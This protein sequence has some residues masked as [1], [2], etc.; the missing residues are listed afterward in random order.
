MA[1]EEEQADTE[2]MLKA[3]QQTYL[4]HA[5]VIFN[6][7]GEVGDRQIEKI[8][9]SLSM[10]RGVGGRATAYICRDFAC[11]VPVTDYQQFV[12]MLQQ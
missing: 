6:P 10:Q 8:D 11:Q 1:G 4:P 12:K 3:V 2:A 7:T 9:P 5:V